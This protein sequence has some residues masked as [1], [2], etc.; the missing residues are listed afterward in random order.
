MEIKQTGATIAGAYQDPLDALE[1]VKEYKPDLVF[2]D[3]EMPGMNGIE[4]AGK[5]SAVDDAVQIV[6]V[7]RV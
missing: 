2:L 5:I 6:F 7:N 3:V 4:L 1:G